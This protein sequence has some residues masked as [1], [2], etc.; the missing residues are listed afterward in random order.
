MSDDTAPAAA[1]ATPA[2]TRATTYQPS[3]SLGDLLL[4]KLR[5]PPCRGTTELGRMLRAKLD[6]QEREAV[7]AEMAL[8]AVSLLG[9][10]P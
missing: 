7:P 3:T 9:G 8:S 5:E 2:P 1:Q 4:Q 10:R 6:Q